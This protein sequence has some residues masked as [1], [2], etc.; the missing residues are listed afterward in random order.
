MRSLLA[1]L[2]LPAVTAISFVACSHGPQVQAAVAPGFSASGH[3]VSIVGV[4]K[5]GRLHPEA[6]KWIGAELSRPFGPQF[7]EAAFRDELKREDPPLFEFADKEAKQNG[8]TEPLLEKF[9]SRA[10][11]DLLLV[12]ELWGEPPQKRPGTD[13][14]P[15][16]M[17]TPAAP[18]YGGGSGVGARGMGPRGMAAPR[19]PQARMRSPGEDGSYGL[20]VSVYSPQTKQWVAAAK[21]TDAGTDSDEGV[22]RLAEELARMLPGATCAGWSFEAAAPEAAP[23]SA[24][25]PASASASASAR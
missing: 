4:M 22:R 20:A 25:V 1:K 9:A 21:L 19:G 8:V 7:C 16:P 24:P 18:G 3:G 14:A 5:D 12:V 13:G 15:A 6:W 2:A 17:G 11:G 23:A 10:K